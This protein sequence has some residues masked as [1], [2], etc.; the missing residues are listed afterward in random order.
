MKS[1]LFRFSVPRL[2]GA[3]A[4]G[5]LTPQAYFAPI[6][7]LG[8]SDMPEP[9]LKGDDWVVVRTALVGICGSDVKQTFLHGNFDNPITSLISFPAVLG[10]EITGTVE[11]VGPSVSRTRI[12]D[13]VA[14]NPWLSCAPRGIKP[15]C[16]ACAEGNYSLCRNFTEGR[17]SPGLHLGNSKDAPGGFAPLLSAHESQCFR[18]PDGVTFEQ[19]VLAD[20]FSVSL[21]AILKAPPPSPDSTVIVYGMGTLGFMCLLAL[22]AMHP[23]VKVVAIARHKHQQVLAARFG[24]NEVITAEPEPRIIERIAGIVGA[25]VHKPWN[26]LPWLLDGVDVIYDNVGSARSLEVGV[27][28][29]APKGTIVVAGV[30]EPRRFEWTPLYFKEVNI[31]GSNGFGAETFKG[32]RKHAFEHYFDLL[33]NGLQDPTPL[34]T[35]HFKLADYRKAFLTCNSKRQTGV[36]KACFEF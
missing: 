12:G 19:V 3:K 1:L 28:V 6:G 35:H 15:A 18:I 7:P 8:F 36:V 32:Q 14:I 23:S 34:I 21:H 16:Q 27:R 4:F 29:V 2:I 30:D 17:L 25:R 13:R 33:S 24:A 5:T 10:H 20:P 26:G 31:I 9:T 11:G 22:K